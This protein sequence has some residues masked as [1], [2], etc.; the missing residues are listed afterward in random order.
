[1]R[2]AC[3]V[4]QGR[5]PGKAGWAERGGPENVSSDEKTLVG[6]DENWKVG[7]DARR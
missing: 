2:A 3:A 6:L 1:M 4:L 7:E 5:F